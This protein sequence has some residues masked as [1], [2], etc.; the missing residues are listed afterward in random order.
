MTFLL[1]RQLTDKEAVTESSS[2]SRGE[3]VCV[4]VPICPILEANLGKK[5]KQHCSDS[6]Y[7]RT[8]TLAD[9]IT[10]LTFHP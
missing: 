9:F 7:S 4:Q 8:E 10:Y 6:E 5:K 2:E 1:G 3:P